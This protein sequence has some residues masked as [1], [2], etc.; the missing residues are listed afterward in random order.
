MRPSS[1]YMAEPPI[2]QIRHIFDP[3]NIHKELIAVGVSTT[4]SAFAAVVLRIFTRLH[5][6]KHGIC[7]DDCRLASFS[8]FCDH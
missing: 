6:T 2:G 3:P 4:I 7:L 5:V 8:I 1:V